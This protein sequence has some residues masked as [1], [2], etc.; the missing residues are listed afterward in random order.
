MSGAADGG[1]RTAGTPCDRSIEAGWA[2]VS[3]RLLANVEE[4]WP[5]GV[6]T[7][8]YFDTKDTASLTRYR[9]GSCLYSIV[10]IV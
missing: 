10:A 3:A 1:Y 4:C 5:I 2:V 6:Y 9:Q 8:V 7:L